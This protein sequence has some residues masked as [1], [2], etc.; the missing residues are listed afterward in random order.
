[1]SRNPVMLNHKG[2]RTI[3]PQK[4]GEQDYESRESGTTT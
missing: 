3:E 1:M 2:Q 4:R